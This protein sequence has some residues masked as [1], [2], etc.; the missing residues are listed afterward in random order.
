MQTI[1][2]IKHLKRYSHLEGG[3]QE[4]GLCLKLEFYPG[5]LVM[6][7]EALSPDKTAGRRSEVL[8]ATPDLGHRKQPPGPVHPKVAHAEGQ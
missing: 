8:V 6:E 5:W 4:E 1:V 7:I 3:L 2:S